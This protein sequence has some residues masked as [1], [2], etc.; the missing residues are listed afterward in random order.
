MSDHEHFAELVLAVKKSGGFLKFQDL[1]EWYNKHYVTV[2]KKVVDSYTK[3]MVEI[4]SYY[5]MQLYLID[6]FDL[7]KA[8]RDGSSHEYKHRFSDLNDD[9]NAKINYRIL[10]ELLGKLVMT[11]V[12]KIPGLRELADARD[13]VKNDV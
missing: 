9:T 3:I 8:L 5:M 11:E 7:C 12:S 10:A 4:V 13:A 1:H 6:V 2:D